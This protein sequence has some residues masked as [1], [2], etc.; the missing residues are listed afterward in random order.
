MKLRSRLRCIS[1]DSA[2]GGYCGQHPMFLE[3]SALPTDEELREAIRA[4]EP[5]P[6]SMGCH[7]AETVCSL[8]GHVS[9]GTVKPCKHLDSSKP[10]KSR[11]ARLLLFTDALLSMV[12]LPFPDPSPVVTVGPPAHNPAI[13]RDDNE[14]L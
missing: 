2:I 10:K 12:M 4:S 14:N 1:C 13:D 9:N 5:S 11:R 3:G 6:V 8:C 7:V